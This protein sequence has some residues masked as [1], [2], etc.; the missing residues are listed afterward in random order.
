[1]SP[2]TTTQSAAEVLQA[3]SST[4]ARATRG[5]AAVG[6]SIRLISQRDA[7]QGQLQ[8]DALQGS[9]VFS[10]L[11]FLISRSLART[12]PVPRPVGNLTNGCCMIRSNGQFLHQSINFMFPRESPRNHPGFHNFDSRWPSTVSPVE[13]I[14]FRH[15]NRC[16]Q[17]GYTGTK[18][19][20]F[21]AKH[22][23][24]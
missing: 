10:I 11:E 3:R 1:V 9:R 8:P 21:Q 16:D 14:L 13:S 17:P 20:I 4:L 18:N 22:D 24:Y 6:L 5:A 2:A 15:H 23:C 12:E 19:E 7:A